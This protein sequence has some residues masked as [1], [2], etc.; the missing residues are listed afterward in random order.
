MVVSVCQLERPVHR[1]RRV[2][3]RLDS[4]D[5]PRPEADDR[6]PGLQ[7]EGDFREGA[8][9][10]ADRD[11]RIRRADDEAIA[12]LVQSCGYGDADPRVGGEPIRPG[13]ETDAETFGGR[14]AAAGRGHHP[15][16]AS[17]YDDRSMVGESPADLL[18]QALLLGAG[19]ARTDHRDIGGHALP[20]RTTTLTSLSGTTITFAI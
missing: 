9:A 6:N 10:P 4:R 2:L 18:G 15:P 13:Q 17:T 16:E 3:R 19:L 7:G 5:L 8:V 11:H 1:A 12:Q 20:Q 14:G